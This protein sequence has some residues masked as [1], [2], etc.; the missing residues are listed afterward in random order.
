MTYL[1]LFVLGAIEYIFAAIWTH[2]LVT[3]QAARLAVLTFVSANLWG[4]VITNVVLGDYGL[5]AV[6]ALGCAIGAGAVCSYL[7]RESTNEGSTG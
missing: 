7:P 1:L 3:K 2:L 6:H 4:L 5:I